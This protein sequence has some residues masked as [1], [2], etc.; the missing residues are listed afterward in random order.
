MS[1]HCPVRGCKNEVTSRPRS[2]SWIFMCRRHWN[3]VPDELREQITRCWRFGER[4]PWALQYQ[5]IEAAAQK[6]TPQR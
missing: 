1:H 4:A 5:A 6:K 3:A 2:D